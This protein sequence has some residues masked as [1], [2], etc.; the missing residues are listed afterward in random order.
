MPLA[1]G[2]LMHDAFAPIMG[3]CRDH[4][5]AILLALA[6]S[7]EPVPS[8]VVE[9]AIAGAVDEYH[10]TVVKRGFAYLEDDENVQYIEKEQSFLIAGL[11][12]AWVLEVLPEVLRRCQIVEVEHDAAYVYDCTCGLGAGIGSKADHD[13]RGMPGQGADVPARLHRADPRDERA[14]VPRVQGDRLRRP[15]LP[16][17][18]GNHAADVLGHPR[19]REAA[20][21]A[22]RPG[23]RPRLAQGQAQAGLQ[24][25]DPQVQRGDVQAGERHLLRLPQAGGPTDGS[26]EVVGQ[27]HLLGRLRG[28]GEDRAQGGEQ[29]AGVGVRRQPARA[30]VPERVPGCGSSAAKPGART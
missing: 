17:Q 4:D 29:G 6:E 22:G 16:G 23:L 18:V 25:A 5:P 14:G 20:G 30:D 27:P 15:E 26:R 12:W 19:G 2:I 8:D 11:V 13:A 10:Q 3:W 24:R 1:T 9:A 21:P 7:R 28:E